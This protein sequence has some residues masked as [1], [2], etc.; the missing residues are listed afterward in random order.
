MLSLM[1]QMIMSSSSA[2]L[3]VQDYGARSGT[4][5]DSTQ[6]FLAAWTQACASTAPPTI[7]VPSGTFLVRTLLFRGPCKN[8]ATLFKIDGTLV[9]PSD[10]SVIGEAGNWLLFNRV[11][12][13]SL[14]GGL[15][16]AQGTALWACKASSSTSSSCPSGATVHM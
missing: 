15:L 8:N 3:S 4:R 16:D 5:F 12:G 14:Q 7:H 1:M 10:Y 9:A 13:V 6:A 2:I 11:T